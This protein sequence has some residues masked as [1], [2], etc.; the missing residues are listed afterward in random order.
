MAFSGFLWSL[1]YSVKMA[2]GADLDQEICCNCRLRP[3]R[4]AVVA[5]GV[6]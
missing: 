6:R 5:I 2:T 4:D 1:W 3:T